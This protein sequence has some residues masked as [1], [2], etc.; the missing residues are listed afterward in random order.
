MRSDKPRRLFNI[1]GH[2]VGYSFAGNVWST[3]GISPAILTCSGDNR[4]PMVMLNYDTIHKSMK[5]NRD[6]HKQVRVVYRACRRLYGI[7]K[8]QDECL[9]IFKIVF[10][11]LHK[12]RKSN[13]SMVAIP[14][15][16]TDA[17]LLVAH[18]WKPT[19]ELSRLIS[20]VIGQMQM[21]FDW[22]R[23][24]LMQFYEDIMPVV[25]RIRKLS[26]RETGR[27]MGLKDEEIDV[28]FDAGLS[29]T[30]MYKLH[31]NSIVVDVM[32]AL[33]DKLLV[34]TE[35]EKDAGVQLSLF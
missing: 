3:T 24:E 4:E 17:L 26:P 12:L 10:P 6:F 8:T 32:T 5:H 18:D 23:E 33:F 21:P 20:R 2:N 25:M 27:L 34:N 22:K 28:M 19:L 35:Q 9:K 14:Q 1:Y 31:G 16:V 13:E 29:N 15:E 11:E 7:E 30:A